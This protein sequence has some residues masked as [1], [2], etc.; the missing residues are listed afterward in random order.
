MRFLL[1]VKGSYH[2]V[3][4]TLEKREIKHVPGTIVSSQGEHETSV[5]VE[6]HEVH[7]WSKLI[8]W[9]SE[10]EAILPFPEQ[11]LLFYKPLLQQIQDINDETQ[12]TF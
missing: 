10:T 6:G 8:K 1:V 7:L 11:T 3:L 5:E 4:D 12:E 9:Y 2:H